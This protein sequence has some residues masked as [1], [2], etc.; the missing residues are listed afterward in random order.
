MHLGD[1]LTGHGFD[2]EAVVVA[3][4]EA[5]SEATLRVAVERGAPRQRVLTNTNTG[6]DTRVRFYGVLPARVRRWRGEEAHLIVLVVDA[7]PL[8]QVPEHHGTVLFEL[9][10]A[11]Q[12][13]SDN[14]E[15]DTRSAGRAAPK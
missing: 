7:E 14:R 11:G 9:K 15:T 2:Y 1:V 10:A 4:Q 12:V 3:G 13:F 8:P 6:T 5:V